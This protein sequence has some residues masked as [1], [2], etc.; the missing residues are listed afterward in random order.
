MS[1]PFWPILAVSVHG[2]CLKLSPH[3]DQVGRFS[4]QTVSEV[5]RTL[6][7]ERCHFGVKMGQIQG[8]I[9]IL[10]DFIRREADIFW[11]WGN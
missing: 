1:D 3:C 10:D 6:S 11:R 9:V 2:F 4:A 8:Y 5:D 7:H